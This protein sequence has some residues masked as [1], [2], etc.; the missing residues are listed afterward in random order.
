MCPIF[1]GVFSLAMCMYYFWSYLS[2]LF[3]LVLVSSF[4]FFRAACDGGRGY[5]ERMCIF[6]S[7]RY[8]ECFCFVVVCLVFFVSSLFLPYGSCVFLWYLSCRN[9]TPILFFF[10]SPLLPLHHVSYYCLTHLI[11]ALSRCEQAATA[12]AVTADG[13]YIVAGTTA[14][15]YFGNNAG[16][17]NGDDDDLGEFFCCTAVRTY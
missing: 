16:S 7:K 8:R 4:F 13:E 15:D 14:G 3:F 12:V 11:L 9:L 17:S 2:L 6:L 5:Y 1:L 10:F